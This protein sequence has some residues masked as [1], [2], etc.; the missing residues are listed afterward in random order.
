MKLIIKFI[1]IFIIA[2]T[3][4][5][6]VILIAGSVNDAR[7]I[8]LPVIEYDPSFA[9]YISSKA[10]NVKEIEIYIANNEN[11][12]RRV[13]LPG[14]ILRSV[15]I[16]SSVSLNPEEYPFSNKIIGSF[17]R[18]M[19]MDPFHVISLEPGECVLAVTL[20]VYGFSD[21]EKDNIWI[22]YSIDEGY[23]RGYDVWTGTAFL[24]VSTGGAN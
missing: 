19:R 17:K 1:L 24:S 15:H 10:G 3:K 20:Y 23:G 6:G 21:T 5:N 8:P 11:V 7:I 22:S 16:K 18:I 2:T 4:L 9:D 13:W 12:Q 14:R